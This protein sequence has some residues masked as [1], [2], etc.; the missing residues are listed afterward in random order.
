[1]TP[2]P[3]RLVI[4]FGSGI[5]TR[6][7]TAAMDESQFARLSQAIA[8]LRQQG[9]EVIV[10]SSGAVAAGLQPLGF[11]RRPEATSALQACAAV[12]QTR[13]MNKYATLLGACGLHVGQLLVTHGDFADP[14]RQE[15]FRNTLTSLLECGNV[16][17]IINENDSVAT[18]ELR[19]GDND[20]LSAG[21]AVIARADLL[22]LFTSVDGLMP[23]GETGK[24]VEIVPDIRKVLAFARDEK[25]E[26]SVGGMSSKLR[27]VERAV[28]AGVETII[29][30]GRR[31]EQIPDLVAGGGIGTR[32]L[33]APRR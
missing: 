27:A 22:I 20:A 8:I 5:L 26:Y 30:N 9:H 12:G 11:A 23:P 19:F 28:S 18:E 7:E 31:P 10:V 3:R 16:I 24:I 13:L 15:N 2:S 14:G 1:M 29:A 25:G 21:L 33:P 6:P 4:K 17:P 32:F